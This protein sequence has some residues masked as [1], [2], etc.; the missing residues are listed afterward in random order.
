MMM[1]VPSDSGVHCAVALPEAI[2]DTPITVAPTVNVIVPDD[3]DGEIVAVKVATDPRVTLLVTE[4]STFDPE[5]DTTVASTL[6][7]DASA[8]VSGVYFALIEKLFGV[9][10]MRMLV[11]AVP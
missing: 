7:S 3:E 11:V 6:L 1:K 2:D 8:F 10:G 9:F 5:T 4:S